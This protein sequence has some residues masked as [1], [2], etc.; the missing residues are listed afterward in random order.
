MNGRQTITRTEIPQGTYGEA[1][2]A[3]AKIVALAGSLE[4]FARRG[5][6]SRNDAQTLLDRH[7]SL[8]DREETP[9]GFMQPKPEFIVSTLADAARIYRRLN[10]VDNETGY[11]S[12]IWRRTLGAIAAKVHA[13]LDQPRLKP[14]LNP[15]LFPIAGAPGV[16]AGMLA[17]SRETLG[18]LTKEMSAEDREAVWWLMCDID[19]DFWEAIQWQLGRGG[20]LDENLFFP[21]LKA[22]VLGFYPLGVESQTMIVYSRSA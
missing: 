10:V 6:E 14:M 4:W 8:V 18:A 17:A 20:A 22:Y 9:T 3:I 13:E 11:P 16:L 5:G 2:P 12:G 21:L 1:T 7:L 15:P 19:K